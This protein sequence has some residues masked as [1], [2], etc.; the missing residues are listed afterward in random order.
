[1]SAGFAVVGGLGLAALVVAP[2]RPWRLAGLA[3]WA[4]GCGGLAVALVPTG[5][6]ALYAG[7][8]AAGLALAAALAFA[9]ARVPWLL[10]VAVLASA[11]ARV[12]VS[13]GATKANLLVP[14]YI[15]VAGAALALAWE[16]AR[17]EP[18]AREL[19]P[20]GWPVAALVAWTCVSLLWSVDR[21][22]GE[23][24]LLFYVLPFG[25]LAIA[26]ARLPWRLG[27]IQA[28]YAQ[29][30][31]MALAFAAIGVV[32][33][34]TR[35]VLWNPKVIVANAYAPSGWFYR[36]NSVF[37]DPSVYGRFL[38]VAIVASL[39]V[40]LLARGAAAWAAAGAAAVTWLGL[41]PSF[42]QSSF[43][44]LG[45]GAVLALALAWRRRA[46]VVVAVA[47]A[48]VVGATVAAGGDLSRSSGGR[49]EL[50]RNG[51]RIAVDHPVGGVGVGGF[52]RAYRDET[53]TRR[54]SHTTP[55]SVAAEEG[56]P[57]V[58]AFVWLLAALAVAAFR[59]T[60]DPARLAVGVALTA[61][62][63]HSL[64]YDALFEDVLFWALASLV[65]VGRRAAPD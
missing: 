11:P 49:S 22:G 6:T 29:L 31:A 59:R 14:L 62:V 3:A 4:A 52:A 28:L 24:E 57:G 61:I 65:V 1:M 55:V 2:R 45:A 35:D 46:V 43:V 36:V 53:G 50:V 58:I 15:V 39:V 60:D 41:L 44:A 16:L 23:I 18:R 12:P 38:V 27:W 42:S 33:Y 10:A 26:L 19:G 32:Q 34:L 20:L 63:V 8:A 21:R 48:A 7:A 37:W 25:L 40:V 47:A 30:A 5:H 56:L 9:F 54:A 13:V 64:F 51:M 17:G